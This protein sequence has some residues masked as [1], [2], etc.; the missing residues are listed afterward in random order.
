MLLEILLK[1][2]ITIIVVGIASSSLYWVWTKQID[3][4][5]TLSN[6]VKNPT[7][8][9]ASYVVIVDENA[10]YQNGKKVGDV[11]GEPSEVEGNLM[12]H[13]FHS[14]M[15]LDIESPFE[16]RRKQYKIIHIDVMADA[17]LTGHG[18]VEGFKKNV[19]CEQVELEN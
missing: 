15:N 4:K 18:M 10:I 1:I 6:L 13:E 2:G 11:I 12:F 17:S 5:A 19:L 8:G 14:S 9:I 7:E 3:V 16:Y